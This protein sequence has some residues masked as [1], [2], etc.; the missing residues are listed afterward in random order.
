MDK[1]TKTKILNLK[2]KKKLK[3]YPLQFEGENN[4]NHLIPF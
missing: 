1:T 4:K 3:T 2:K